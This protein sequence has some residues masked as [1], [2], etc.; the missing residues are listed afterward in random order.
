[1]KRHL[2]PITG[3]LI[4]LAIAWLFLAFPARAESSH[5]QAALPQ[6]SSAHYT[7]DWS[8]AGQTSGGAS[9]STHYALSQVSI[10][11][12]AAAD[13]SASSH[14]RLCSGARCVDSVTFRS[15]VYLPAVS[16]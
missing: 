15:I 6:M 4:L 3:G 5:P 12:V 9:G 14:Y 10:S 7:L 8:V 13:S 2:L 11:Q 1:M 16:R